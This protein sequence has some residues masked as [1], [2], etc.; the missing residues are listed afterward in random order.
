M[1]P[2]LQVSASVLIN[3]SPE[4]V[5][6]IL[7]DPVHIAAYLYGTETITDWRVGS[8][9]IFQGSYQGQD[10]LDKGIVKACSPPNQL[11]YGYWSGFS[12]LAD[13]PE[14][15]ATIT[16]RVEQVDEELVKFT[17]EQK[18]F[19]SEENRAHSENGLPAILEAMK[20]LAESL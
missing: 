11:S 18:G 14:N 7:T 9:I 19:G 4:K 3:S 5:W 10:Y 13:I 17:W 2:T 20:K 1:D 8:P 16:Y 15:Y 12:G 6:T